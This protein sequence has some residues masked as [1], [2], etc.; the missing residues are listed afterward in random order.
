MA[1]YKNFLYNNDYDLNEKYK[2]NDTNDVLDK[3]YENFKHKF[4]EARNNPNIFI[5]DFICGVDN[6]NEPLRWTYKVMMNGYIIQKKKKYAFQE[7]LLMKATMKLDMIVFVNGTVV[8]VSDN[9]FLTIGIKS[10]FDDT[11]K[12]ELIK[13][14]S[15]DYNELI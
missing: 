9:Y 11:I 13:K 5:I 1:N 15:E 6:K 7:C 4:V 14:L 12:T 8:D 10:N 3:L 2:S